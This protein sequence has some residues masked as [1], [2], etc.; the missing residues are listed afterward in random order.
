[1]AGRRRRPITVYASQQCTR[2]LRKNMFNDSLWP[3]FTRIP[4]ARN[5]VIRFKPFRAG[6]SFRIGKYRIRSISVCHPVESC[7]FVI[8]DER[9]SVAITGDPGPT[10]ALW[11]IVTRTPDLKAVVLETSFPNEMQQLADV[12]GHLTPQTLRSELAKFR[13]NGPSISLYHHKPAYLAQL[14]EE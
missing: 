5:P 10:Q 3:D 7:G 4:S 14:K 2:T 9:T 11:N 1:M 8:S 12:S 6:S 13:H